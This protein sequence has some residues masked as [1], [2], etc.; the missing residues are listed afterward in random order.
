MENGGSADIIEPLLLESGLWEY[1]CDRQKR[2]S[3]ETKEVLAG[4]QMFPDFCIP[5]PVLAIGT[6]S[7]FIHVET[8]LSSGEVAGII[9]EEEL[10]QLGGLPCI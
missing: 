5:A 4:R 9:L 2:V 7:D 3:R 6:H 8:R 10:V 1:D